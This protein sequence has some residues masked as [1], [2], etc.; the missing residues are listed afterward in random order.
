MQY[1][2]ENINRHFGL[3]SDTRITIYYLD[4][5]DTRFIR[6]SDTHLPDY[7][8]AH[9]RRRLPYPLFV[10][11]QINNYHQ[12]ILSQ[13][14]NYHQFILPKSTNNYHHST[15]SQINNYHQS[16]LSQ[17]NKQLSPV[18]TV[19]NK[20]LSPVYT[21]PNQQTIITTP[22]CP[23]STHCTLSLSLITIPTTTFTG[24]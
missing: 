5:G 12:S 11:S 7:A 24:V 6:S 8:A 9:S 4:D 17:I 16:I 18:Y 23:K 20:Q 19:S 15:L 21:V 22:H 2:L 13:I 3:T 10:L 14:N 1:R